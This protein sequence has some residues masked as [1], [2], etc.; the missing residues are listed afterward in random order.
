VQPLSPKQDIPIQLQGSSDPALQLVMPQLTLGQ[1]LHPFSPQ[2]MLLSWG[3]LR[4][5]MFSV[6][7]AP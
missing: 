6:M 5:R 1:H 2:A 3:C 4:N 7:L